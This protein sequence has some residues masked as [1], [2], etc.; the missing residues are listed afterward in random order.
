MKKMYII[1]GS[2]LAVCLVVGVWIGTSL[3]TGSPAPANDVS[4][5]VAAVGLAAVENDYDPDIPVVERTSTEEFVA[6]MMKRFGVSKSDL[7]K[8]NLPFDLSDLSKYDDMTDE[9]RIEAMIADFGSYRDNLGSK[10][11]AAFDFS[12]FD[13][14]NFDFSKFDP[15]DCEIPFDLS[16]LEKY[17][18]MTN[19]E[20]LAAAQADLQAILDGLAADGLITKEQ[21]D[22]VKDF[23]LPFEMPDFSKYKGMTKEEICETARADIQKIIDGLLAD[24]IITQEQID[25]VMNAVKDFELPF[26]LPDFSKYKEMTKEEIKDAVRADIQAIIDQLLAEG[27]ITQEQ[28]DEFIN[29]VKNYELPFELP[30]FSK[31]EGKTKEEIIT[32][33]KADLQSIVSALIENGIITQEQID[34]A[35]NVI[36]RIPKYLA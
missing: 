30:D 12:N 32:A 16:F 23:E 1:I 17:K 19:D 7:E 34:E 28:I 14:S 21:I 15:D 13:I 22:K 24:G 27:I 18:D 8:M 25:E 29:E 2:I 31:Y 26:E 36:M 9:E 4:E 3:A 11:G 6:N 10:P 33:A 20:R 5:P 35:L